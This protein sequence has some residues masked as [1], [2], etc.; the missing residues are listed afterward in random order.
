MCT[1]YTL[2]LSAWQVRNLMRHY[3]LIGREVI[4]SRSDALEIYPNRSG[5]VVVAQ[6]G[7]RIVREDMLCGFPPTTG[8]RHVVNFSQPRAQD[9]ARLAG[10]RAPLRRAYAAVKLL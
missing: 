6:D 7:E 1:L 9:V 4:R 5:P 8:G 2:R 3:K 10:S